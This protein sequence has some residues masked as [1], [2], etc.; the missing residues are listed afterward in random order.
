MLRLKAAVA[1]L[2]LGVGLAVVGIQTPAM[3][4]SG[5]P[6][7][8]PGPTIGGNRLATVVMLLGPSLAQYGAGLGGE[9][10]MIER[11]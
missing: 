6:S 11:G 2:T 4:C 5:C 9:A 3:A 10:A 7:Q 8:W 1:A